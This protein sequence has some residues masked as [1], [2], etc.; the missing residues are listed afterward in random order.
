MIRHSKM[1]KILYK[2]L[3]EGMVKIHTYK[4][5]T[6]YWVYRYSPSGVLGKNG[7]PL[8]SEETYLWGIIVCLPQH[9][10]SQ[11]DTEKVIEG[12]RFTNDEYGQDIEPYLRK[13]GRGQN[14]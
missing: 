8:P 10:K 13:T 7:M 1:F 2:D 5:Y 12:V 3:D 4:D 9:I 6:E 11:N 14:G